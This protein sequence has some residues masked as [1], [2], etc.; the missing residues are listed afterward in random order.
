MP[1]CSD[2]GADYDSPDG[3]PSC[4]GQSN[5]VVTC[6]RCEESYQGGDSCPACGFAPIPIPCERHPLILADGRCVVCGRAICGDCRGNAADKRV[7][8]CDEHG[9]VNVIEGWAQ[10]YDDANEV[11]ARLIR[12]NLVAE[13]I[14]ARIFS[15][16]DVM[17]SVALGEL[18]VVRVLVPVWDY[19]RAQEIIRDH[20]GIEG[21]VS[22]ACPNCGEAYESGTRECQ[23]CGASLIAGRGA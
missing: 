10:V 16:K 6:P 20:T 7:Y 1:R 11:E 13:G 12:D 9:S 3:C 4:A 22:F 23:S 5:A 18:S 19:E 14:E 21:A 17:F 2:C 15:Q 8:L